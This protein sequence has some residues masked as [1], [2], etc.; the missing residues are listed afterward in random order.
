MKSVEGDSA[1]GRRRLEKTAIEAGKYE[2]LNEA[3]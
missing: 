1:K 2:A 3:L